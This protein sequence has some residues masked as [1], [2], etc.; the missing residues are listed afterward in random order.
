M[1]MPDLCF[2]ASFKGVALCTF[3]Y[4]SSSS[5]SVEQRERGRMM[6]VASGEQSCLWILVVIMQKSPQTE[7]GLLVHVKEIKKKKKLNRVCERVRQ[8]GDRGRQ[9]LVLFGREAIPAP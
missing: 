2:V 9:R 4:G 7:N 6:A 3:A 1:H 8:R 5:I